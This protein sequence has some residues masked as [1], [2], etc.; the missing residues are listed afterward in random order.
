MIHEFSQHDACGLH[1]VK[2]R[3]WYLCRDEEAFRQL[4]RCA[5]H[6]FTDGFLPECYADGCEYSWIKGM[7]DS[8]LWGGE[9]HYA[10]DVDGRAAGCLNVSRCGGAYR[11]TGFLRLTLLPKYCGQGI[12]S[13]AVGMLLHQ[14]FQ[15]FCDEEYV[16]LKGGF[17]RLQACVIGVNPAAERVLVKNGFVYEGT[18]RQVACKDN[19]VYDAKVYG[20]LCPRPAACSVLALSEE[21]SEHMANIHQLSEER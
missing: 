1:A 3:Q 9:F 16:Y 6:R 12:G 2:L 14:A 15:S 19:Q 20:I 10:V 4:V 21:T 5:D 11:R 17:E 8:L 7:V 13:Q 18:L